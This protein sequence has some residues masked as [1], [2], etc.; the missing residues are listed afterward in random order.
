MDH[1][2]YC[3]FPEFVH[4]DHIFRILVTDGQK[5]PKLDLPLGYLHV[6]ALEESSQ[7]II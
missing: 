4:R 3:I 6:L 7:L 5:I 2:P 1:P